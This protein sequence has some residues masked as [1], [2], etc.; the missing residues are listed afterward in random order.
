MSV[1]SWRIPFYV[2]FTTLPSFG[3][4]RPSTQALSMLSELWY[5]F[6]LAKSLKL[7]ISVQAYWQQ[8]SQ[9]C[10]DLTLCIMYFFTSQG[11]NTFKTVKSYWILIRESSKDP[12]Q[13][14]LVKLMVIYYLALWWWQ[15]FCTVKKNV[16]VR[17]SYIIFRY[18]YM[19]PLDSLNKWVLADVYYWH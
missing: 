16:C 9:E 8:T 19:Q 5:Y 18:L 10:L 12:R 4:Q 3:L 14:Y 6:V 17:N 1:S 11:K 2:V 15:C 7:A 13:V